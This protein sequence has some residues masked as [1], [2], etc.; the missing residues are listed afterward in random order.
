M[1]SWFYLHWKFKEKSCLPSI[2]QVFLT[3][4]KEMT[5]KPSKVATVKI[6]SSVCMLLS[7]LASINFFIP[8]CD[9]KTLFFIKVY[10]YW[11]PDV[12]P[13][14]MVL[15]S[16]K[17]VIWKK[18]VFFLSWL[19]FGTKPHYEAPGD[20]LAKINIQTQW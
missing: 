8:R 19:G 5:P 1:F 4:W 12:F 3:V 9:W 20:F 15:C 6:F 11:Y 16:L 13:T 14:A 10:W 18:S 7:Q 17:Q 2:L